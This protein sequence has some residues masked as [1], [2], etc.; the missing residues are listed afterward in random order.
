MH[1]LAA[2]VIFAATCAP[3]TP[4][5][6]ASFWK[7][8]APAAAPAPEQDLEP[9]ERA[10]E[11]GRLVDAGQLIDQQA[12]AGGATPRLK[13]MVGELGLA[14]GEYAAAIDAFR[15]A[16][17]EADLGAKARQ[18]Q[19]LALAHMGRVDEAL[20]LLKKVV[21]EQPSAWRA[22]SALGAM[23]DRSSAWADAEAAYQ[24]AIEAA[25]GAAAPYN[26]RGYSYLLQGRLD[27]AAS[28]FV[29]ALQRKPDLAEARANL[30]LTLA[31][32]GDYDRATDGV[33]AADR[34][35]LLN[36]AGLAA[37]ARGDF[38][39][40]EALLQQAMA[41]K[42]EFYPRA[43]ENLTLVRELQSRVKVATHDAH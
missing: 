24:H 19:A 29:A 31:L 32:R 9:I 41:T 36:N 4:A 34:A 43:S 13:L 38:G 30:R 5:H 10:L 18:G 35:A 37:G 3:M 39:K 17:G 2:L 21:A 33:G 11:E 42:G 22:W 26:N 12:L 1:G 23:Y 27:A 40:A 14:R 28:D 6:A 16:A 7:R 20:P 15:S 25:P 8:S